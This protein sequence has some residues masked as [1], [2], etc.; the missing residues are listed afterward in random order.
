MPQKSK[1]FFAGKIK[2]EEFNDGIKFLAKACAD[3]NFEITH[4]L[5]IF[6]DEILDD[7]IEL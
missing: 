3:D 1:D 6:D 7:E 2:E 5:R 4:M